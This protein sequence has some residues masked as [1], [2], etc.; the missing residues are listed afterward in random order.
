MDESRYCSNCRAELPPA[1]DSCP[2]CG[3]YAG[4]LFDERSLE[5]RTRRG[6]AIAFIVAL[7][8]A[9]AT[10]AWLAMSDARPQLPWEKKEPVRVQ[11]TLPETR[12]VGDRPG[13]KARRTAGASLNE[14][15]ATRI[16]RRHFAST[17]NIANQCLVIMSN[18]PSKGDY[19]FTVFNRCDSIRLG[20]W[21]VDG[22]T[23]TAALAK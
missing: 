5:P 10:T 16:L 21:Q 6:F 4:D 13:S 17:T 11:R 14:A 15:E 12:V 19:F 7:V 9:G 2:E 18:G 20:R 23:G 22:K 3:V 1:A 8:V